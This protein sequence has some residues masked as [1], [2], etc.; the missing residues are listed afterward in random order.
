MAALYG[1]TG[2]RKRSILLLASLLLVAGI[3]LVLSICIVFGGQADCN[4]PSAALGSKSEEE[5][6]V[7]IPPPDEP[8]FMEITITAGE[9]TLDGVLFD[10]DTAK[11]I[12]A[13]LPL[14]VDLWHPAQGFARAFHLPE[15]VPDAAQRTRQY[16]Q[17][18]LA[19]WFEGPSV[20]IFYGDH[21]QETIVPVVT[22]G[23]L[24]DGVEL[25]EDYGGS[26]TISPKAEAAQ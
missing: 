16:E 24:T 11:A 21:L 14:T 10:N 23:R 26:I 19:Y 25:F 1:S 12:A 13:M 4:E 7:H 6:P 9:E 17:G 2:M 15:Q 5:N 18:G 22:V 20:A 8:V 3:L